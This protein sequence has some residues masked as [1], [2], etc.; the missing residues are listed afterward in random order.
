MTTITGSLSAS[1]FAERLGIA[2]YTVR[3]FMDKMRVAMKSNDSNPMNNL[4][5]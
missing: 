4:S 3:M 2:S 1:H 5:G